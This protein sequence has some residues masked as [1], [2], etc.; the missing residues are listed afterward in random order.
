MM[1]I[2]LSS[3]CLFSTFIQP[4][5]NV[6]LGGKLGGTSECADGYSADGLEVFSH[7]PAPSPW[8]E[9]WN[10]LINPVVGPV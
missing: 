9:D 10:C 8:S 2:P 1:M 5:I 7:W 3:P 4:M 6:G